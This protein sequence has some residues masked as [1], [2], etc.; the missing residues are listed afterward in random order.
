MTRILR[1]VEAHHVC[2][3]DPLHDRYGQHLSKEEVESLIAP[4]PESIHLVNEWLAAHGLY[5]DSLSR[6]PANDW[7]FIK[8]PVSLAEE[9]LKTVCAFILYAY[10][11]VRRV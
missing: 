3:S 7:V 10:K 9:M 5:E 1:R 8:V 11:R 2:L 4:E 6:S